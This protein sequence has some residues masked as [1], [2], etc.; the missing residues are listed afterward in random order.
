MDFWDNIPAWVEG[1][2]A[3][4]LVTIVVFAFIWLIV[5]GLVPLLRELNEDRKKLAT[6]QRE[7]YEGEVMPTLKGLVSE[8]KSAL[9]TQREQYEAKLA[10]LESERN[11]ERQKLV[12]QIDRLSTEVRTLTD[13]ITALEKE[14]K[15]KD[16]EIAD[17]KRQLADKQTELDTALAKLAAAEAGK[18]ANDAAPDGK[19]TDAKAA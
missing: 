4:A 8:L 19:A 5:R 14:T 11:A 10:L 17:L 1:A 15:V 16:E 7:F 9:A 18:H 2:S 13:R 3:A 6:E 12:E